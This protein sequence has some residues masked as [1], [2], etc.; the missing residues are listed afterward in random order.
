M[1]LRQIVETM[2]AT[3]SQGAIVD[4]VKNYFADEATTRDYGNNST[5]NKAEMIAKMESF[6][7]AIRTVNHIKHHTTIVDRNFSASEFTFE[8][9]MN[10][11]SKIFW[12]EIIRRV[13]N[14]DGKVIQ[15]EYF[16]AA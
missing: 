1:N 2:D 6:A 12:H 4:A 13:W 16:N 15:E 14:E 10:D 5:A 9:V 8:F 3:V 7:G 11:G